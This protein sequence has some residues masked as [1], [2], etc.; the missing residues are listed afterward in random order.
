MVGG[1]CLE[2]FYRLATTAIFFLCTL[3]RE[4]FFHQFSIRK[5]C[6][7]MYLSPGEQKVWNE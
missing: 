6:K 7:W 5:M 2:Y 1:Q 3:K 4:N